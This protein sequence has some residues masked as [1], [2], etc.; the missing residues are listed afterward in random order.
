MKSVFYIVLWHGDQFLIPVKKTNVM[1]LPENYIIKIAVLDDSA[2]YTSILK[3]QIEN[4]MTH[5]SSEQQ[6][7]FDL[8]VFTNSYDFLHSFPS[9][10]DILFLD[11][12]LDDGVNALNILEEIQPFR[13]G[14]KV[15]MVSQHDNYFTTHKAISKG[16][17]TFIQKDKDLLLNT[18]NFVDYIVRSYY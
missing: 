14:I 12:Y 11:Y 8:S 15:A 9:S 3:R 4:T 5:I 10:H 13:N 6:R 18:S 1:N 17:M 16:A 7:N 2:F